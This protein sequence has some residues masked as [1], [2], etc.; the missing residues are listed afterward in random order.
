[1]P[2][3]LEIPSLEFRCASIFCGSARMYESFYG[4]EQRPFLTVPTL[5]RYYPAS[6][7]EAAYQTVTRAVQRCEGPVAIFGGAGLGKTMCCLRI[8][9]SIPRN[10]EVITLASAQLITR[11]ALLQSLL[12]ELRLPCRADSEGELRLSLLERL[13][14]SEE[15]RSSGLVLIVDE[16]QTLSIKLLEELR[17]L[18]NVVH[19]GVPRLR[20]VL[21]GTLR[22]EETLTHPQMESLNQ[23]LAARCYLTPLNHEESNRYVQHKIEL[24]GQKW[25][26]I[27]TPDGLEAIFRAS[28]GIPRLIDQV[29]DQSLLL[30]AKEKICPINAAVV[31]YAWSMLQQLPN[32]WSDPAP[33][34]R[35][36]S[37][38]ESEYDEFDEP[39]SQAIEF[40]SLDGSD[41]FEATNVDYENPSR[42]NAASVTEQSTPGVVNQKAARQRQTMRELQSELEPVVSADAQFIPSQSAPSTGGDDITSNLLS[43]FNRGYDD[44]FKIPIQSL[45]EYQTL[46]G[47][48]LGDLNH[49]A[50]MFE[51]VQGIH[52]GDAYPEAESFFEL[53]PKR[54]EPETKVSSQQG[55]RGNIFTGQGNGF[56]VL[57]RQIEDEMRDL[58]T[59]LNRDS[60]S[61]Q[62]DQSDTIGDGYA[63]DIYDDNDMIVESPELAAMGS[64]YQPSREDSGAAYSHLKEEAAGPLGDDR[65]M[66]FVE[67]GTLNSGAPRSDEAESEAPP[68]RARASIHPYAR[69]FS[70]LRNS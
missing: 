4:F 61:D 53:E 21:C 47:I 33:N 63:D 44:E 35:S 51:E 59:D 26:S 40:G 9:A 10:Y 65:D 19:A 70:Q 24:C 30:G 6:S 5:D 22:L 55:I 23:R 36:S 8:A 28:D 57:E 31:G 46:S 69:L 49:D 29:A 12:Y 39:E 58:V 1:M 67:E 64:I 54:S 16:A 38:N 37:D 66:I 15:N 14:P 25:E 20:L 32:P 27:L 2:R 48:A 43:G 60:N 34:L 13:Q 41:D 68:S 3:T 52:E 62:R 7:I 45:G 42:F 56:E 50:L 11:R 18:T 17:I